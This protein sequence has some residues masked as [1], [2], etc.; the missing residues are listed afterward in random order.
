M[1]IIRNRLDRQTTS[2]RNSECKQIKWIK[3][4]IVNYMSF[5]SHFKFIQLISTI[6]VVW[7]VMIIVTL[8]WRTSSCLLSIYRMFS[9]MRLSSAIWLG[10][11][12]FLGYLGRYADNLELTL[13]Q[14][15]P[16]FTDFIFALYMQHVHI[17]VQS[18]VESGYHPKPSQ[19][20]EIYFLSI[21]VT[22]CIIT[23]ICN[24]HT[25]SVYHIG[26]TATTLNTMSPFETF[27]VDPLPDPFVCWLSQFLRLFDR[28]NP[29][30][31][32]IFPR[33]GPTEGVSTVGFA[34]WPGVVSVTPLT[35]T[36]LWMSLCC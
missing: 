13:F 23:H 7:Y 10:M 30:S 32:W 6:R 33:K 27:W 11:Y 34:H 35:W 5:F 22:I 17:W 8:S 15:K 3:Q 24:A 2:K 20:A 18:Q 14:V 21:N 26:N 19:W 12:F 1:Y 36:I 28:F 9:L 16:Q 29:Y 31:P 25:Y 4:T